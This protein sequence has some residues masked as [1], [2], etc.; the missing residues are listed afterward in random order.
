MATSILPW[1]GPAAW[2]KPYKNDIPINK[3]LTSQEYF[4]SVDFNA[5]NIKKDIEYYFEVFDNDAVNGSKS[6]KT[7]KNVFHKLSEKELAEYENDKNESID[8]KI[9]QSYKKR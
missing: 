2:I 6:T 4:Y 3:N 1:P 8:S 7:I 5:I 9:K